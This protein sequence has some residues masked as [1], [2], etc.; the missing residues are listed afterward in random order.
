MFRNCMWDATHNKSFGLGLTAI[1]DVRKHIYYI[2]D[3]IFVFLYISEL[4]I[5]DL[6][7]Y[8]NMTW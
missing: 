8:E 6:T 1:N 4:C 2:L 7:G 3:N 5:E